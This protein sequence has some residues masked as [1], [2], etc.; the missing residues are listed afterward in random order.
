[1]S[2][3]IPSKEDENLKISPYRKNEVPYYANEFVVYEEYE[4]VNGE[5]DAWGNIEVNVTAKNTDK[6]KVYT[7]HTYPEHIYL[8]I[9]EIVIDEETVRLNN[10]QNRFEEIKVHRIRSLEAQKSFLKFTKRFGLLGISE[11]EYFFKRINE[12]AFTSGH[13]NLVLTDIKKEL[14]NQK[15]IN[16]IYRMKI[17]VNYLKNWMDDKIT[18]EQKEDLMNIVND[19][20]PTKQ[21]RLQLKNGEFYPSVLFSSLMDLAWWQL[22]EALLKKTTYRRC[23]NERCGNIFAVDHGNRDYCPPYPNKDRSNCEHN[24][25]RRLNYMR[26]KPTRS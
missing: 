26:N 24:H 15:L 8:Q 18:E 20:L 21:D 2:T 6:Y 14:V 9:S 5:E 16:Q 12:E 11:R 25:N 1:M 4:F 22:H 3:L 23:K 17:A 7:L 10:E 19:E 13:R